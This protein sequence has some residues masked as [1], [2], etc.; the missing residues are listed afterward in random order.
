MLTLSKA[1]ITVDGITVFAD[2]RDENQFWYLPGPVG[3][4]RNREDNR[5][6]LSLI[7]YRN[8]PSGSGDLGGGFMTFET[9]LRLPEETERKILSQLATLAPDE[10]QLAA[11]PFDSG[12][13]ECVALDLQGSG[14]TEGEPP[15]EGGF[16]MVEEIL[17]TSKPSLFGDNSAI[18]SLT[19]SQE[20]ATLLETAMREGASPVGVIYHLNFTA[21]RPNLH[22]RIKADWE[23]IYRH[24]SGEVE[25]NVYFVQGAIEGG[26]EELREN[27]SIEVEVVDFTSEED[28]AQKEEQALEFFKTTLLQKLFEPKLALGQMQDEANINDLARTASDLAG[29][30]KEAEESAKMG[31]AFKLKALRQEE[32]RTATYEYNRSDA[33]TR[34]YAPQAFIGLLAQDLE[35]LDSHIIVANLDDP[36]FKTLDIEVLPP[37]ISFADFGLASAH[38]G[39]DYPDPQDASNNQSADV[40]FEGDQQG[41]ER[42]QFFLNSNFDLGYDYHVEY[43][44]QSGSDWEGEKHTYEIPPEHTEDR[45][46][47]LNLSKDVG[48]LP[49]SVEPNDIDSE[50]VESVE[51]HLRYA[52][53][54]GWAREKT[55]I[56]KPGDAAQEWKLRLTDPNHR[57]YSYRYVFHLPGG[58]LWETDW[59]ERE[60]NSLLVNDPFDRQLHVAII[61]AVDPEEIRMAFVDLIY[62]DPDNDVHHEESVRLMQEDLKQGTP[63]DIFLPLEDP[64]QRTFQYRVT[65]LGAD[66]QPRRGELT[67]TQEPRIFVTEPAPV[68]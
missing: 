3:L 35:D 18:F 55:F 23:Q 42:R 52:S 7:K 13:V 24:F 9:S 20:G 38:V 67:T 50:L 64:T 36:F 54:T 63:Q 46:L 48:F 56:V 26:F 4:A 45:R 30:A 60:A 15:Q 31:I 66:N 44:F 19:L 10:P 21:V 32:R 11:V 5:G 14:G 51:V 49:I 65:L 40:L 16:R 39:L 43:V 25:G 41:K 17:G 28:A 8:I 61:P 53:P 33:V 34:E 1:A 22:V 59:Q 6:M 62:D 58:D 37:P 27:K 68:A 47:Q 29:A 57:A 2:H 12:T